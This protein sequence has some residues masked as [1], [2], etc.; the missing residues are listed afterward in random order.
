MVTIM[1]MLRIYLGIY[2][3]IYLYQLIVSS[4]LKMNKE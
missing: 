2:L 3:G 4:F 1:N